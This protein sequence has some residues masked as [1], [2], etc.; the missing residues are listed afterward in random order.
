[1]GLDR[2]GP[3][4]CMWVNKIV[5]KQRHFRTLIIVNIHV[6]PYEG[7]NGVPMKFVINKI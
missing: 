3:K 6:V 1:M 5:T 4:M 2:H 7:L